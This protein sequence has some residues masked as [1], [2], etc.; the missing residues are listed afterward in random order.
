MECD[1][2]INQRNAFSLFRVY[3]EEIKPRNENKSTIVFQ[4]T[5]SSFSLYQTARLCQVII[6]IIIKLAFS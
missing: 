4:S 1:M 2:S 6:I 5:A 3:N